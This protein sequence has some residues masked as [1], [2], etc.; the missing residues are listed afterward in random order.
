[1]LILDKTGKILY[2]NKKGAKVIKSRYSLDYNGPKKI[3]SNAH[4][5]IHFSSQSDLDEL[6]KK[7][8]NF[9]GID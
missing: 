3:V 8:Q 5:L 6:L 9:T 1:M 2:A 4:D 7:P